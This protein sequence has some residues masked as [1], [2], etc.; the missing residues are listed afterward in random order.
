MSFTNSQLEGQG[1]ELFQIGQ[2]ESEA[3]QKGRKTQ[4]GVQKE[5][6][7]E[8]SQRVVQREVQGVASPREDQV[9]DQLEDQVEGRLGDQ[10]GIP[11]EGG[12]R[13]DQG[14]EGWWVAP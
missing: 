9:G 4:K 7:K 5:G 13:E 14:A 12:Q 2:G 11:S 1:E 6:R 8:G 3:F 10:E